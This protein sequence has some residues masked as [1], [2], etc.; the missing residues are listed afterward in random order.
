VPSLE[1]T[2]VPKASGSEV[3]VIDNLDPDAVMVESVP[4]L[5]DAST[6]AD[7][8]VTVF[9]GDDLQL[10]SSSTASGAWTAED[11]CPATNATDKGV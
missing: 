1:L 9:S 2:L 4:S 6:A 10:I 11:I 3:L 5:Q 7:P 8:N